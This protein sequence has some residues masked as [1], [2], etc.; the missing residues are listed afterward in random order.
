MHRGTD[1]L[2]PNPWESVSGAVGRHWTAV[3]VQLASPLECSGADCG[4]G[5]G[6]R[7][8]GRSISSPR[9]PLCSRRRHTTTARS[10]YA[11]SVPRGQTATYLHIAP[12]TAS[13]TLH[14]DDTAGPLFFVRLPPG[15]VWLRA[16]AAG[17]H[18]DRG[19]GEQRRHRHGVHHVGSLVAGG[20]PSGRRRRITRVRLSLYGMG[21]G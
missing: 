5:R 15:D 10:R 1:V 9:W 17:D 21:G 13:H 4:S 16:G 12:A 11:R 19:A 7:L 8:F 18:G 20:R 6:L 3:S 2:G 14:R